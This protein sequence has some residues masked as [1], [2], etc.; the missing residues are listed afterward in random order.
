M[1]LRGLLGVLAALLL[2]SAAGA[3][4]PVQPAPQRLGR[5]VLQPPG[6]E[7]RQTGTAGGGQEPGGAQPPDSKRLGRPVLTTP[8]PVGGEAPRGEA[9]RA[10]TAGRNGGASSEGQPR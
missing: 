5:P 4:S 2:A 6:A 8:P 7:G 3:E 9:S 1:G 10:P